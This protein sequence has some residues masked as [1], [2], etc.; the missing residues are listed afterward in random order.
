MVLPTALLV[1]LSIVIG[2]AAG[3]LHELCI[4]ASADLLG[5]TTGTAP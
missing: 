5:A 3:P 2:V 1:L 4:R